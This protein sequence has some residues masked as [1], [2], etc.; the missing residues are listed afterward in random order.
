MIPGLTQRS[1]RLV[2]LVSVFGYGV[3]RRLIWV[4]LLWAIGVG[5]LT[6]GVSWDE[7]SSMVVLFGT[8]LPGFGTGRSRDTT[9]T[10][11]L[12]EFFSWAWLIAIGVY[13]LPSVMLPLAGSYSV[14]ATLWARLTPAT[15][16]EVAVARLVRVLGPTAVLAVLGAVWAMA[17]AT[18]H[19]LSMEALLAQ[20]GG[21]PAH[22]FCSAGVV[23]VLG[24]YLRTDLGRTLSA[25]LAL[26]LPVASFLLFV[27]LAFR[28][29]GG[30]KPWWPYACPFVGGV[31]DQGPHFASIAAV[32]GL[33]LTLSVVCRTGRVH[34]PLRVPCE[35]TSS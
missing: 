19:N 17:C 29:E 33:L 13:V 18:Y 12:A 30:W 9:V 11:L 22:L 16:R 1:N 15:P 28:M 5:L 8:S 20:A 32:G 27:T 26:L 31:G 7:G 3:T 23:A 24:S 14:S 10:L 4:L 34:Y 2:A 35:E 21:L 25:F 6:F